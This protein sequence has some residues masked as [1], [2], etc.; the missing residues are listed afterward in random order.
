MALTTT[1]AL[2]DG[3]TAATN[4]A[5]GAVVYVT[6]GNM[7]TIT[8]Q[9]STGMLLWNVVLTSDYFPQLNQTFQ[10]Y[11][12]TFQ[13][14]VPMP[15]TPC[16]FTLVSEATDGNNFY[17]S[18]YT[19][20]NYL[21]A[22]SPTHFT[23]YVCTAN[24]NTAAMNVVQDGVTGVAG[25][26]VLLVNQTTPSQN[27]P[28]AIGT[29]AANIAALSRPPDWASGQVLKAPQMF[30]VSEGTLFS[31]STWKVV[32][33]GAVTVDTTNTVS[34]YPQVAFRGNVANLT[35]SG[36]LT[37]LWLL[38]NTQTMVSCMIT[39]NAANTAQVTAININ[40][41]AGAGFVTLV[42]ETANGGGV[43]TILNW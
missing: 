27:G 2:A 17:Q 13:V 3:L 43:V 20:F 34:I 25:D 31:N 7:L 41:G 11:G 35:A 6:P 33:T 10:Q 23:R 19:L 22:A 36:N 39:T 9:V 38:S 18:T 21:R 8:P 26:V 24:V 29:V 40:G 1:I 16:R 5:N 12:P 14:Q 15:Q 4:Q 30:E 37:G 32:S 42:P 28:W